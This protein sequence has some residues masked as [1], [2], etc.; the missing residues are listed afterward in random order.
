MTTL[1]ST[2]KSTF[3]VLI[4]DDLSEEGLKVFRDQ[5]NCELIIKLKQ[6]LDEL[7]KNIADVDAC[8]VRSGTQI[9]REVIDAAKQL[10]VIGRAGVGLDNVDVEAASKRGIVVVNTPGGNTISAAE[11]AFLEPLPFK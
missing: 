10:K 3:K 5:K 9:T 4:C 1:V 6:P 7:R 2:K 11:L 8:V